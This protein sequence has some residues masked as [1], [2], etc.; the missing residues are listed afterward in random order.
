MEKKIVF[1]A[2]QKIFESV[3]YVTT[4]LTIENL[5]ST[6]IQK[7]LTVKWH[8]AEGFRWIVLEFCIDY[9]AEDFGH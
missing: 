8:H 7:D 5:K 6:A 9:N 3:N 4:K 1:H 2:V